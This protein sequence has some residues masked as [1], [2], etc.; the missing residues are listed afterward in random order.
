M[1]VYDMVDLNLMIVH[2]DNVEN[3]NNNFD[4]VD[5]DDDFFYLYS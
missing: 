5:V 4:D 3:D 2:D 1:N